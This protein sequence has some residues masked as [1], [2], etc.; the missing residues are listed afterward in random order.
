M[1][2]E[3]REGQLLFAHCCLGPRGWKSLAMKND[4]DG[5][6]AQRPRRLEGW[7]PVEACAK[8]KGI[9]KL[10]GQDIYNSRHSQM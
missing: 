2:Q 9:V 8:C 3:Y 7:R 4:K 5:S 1:S 6:V 10:Q